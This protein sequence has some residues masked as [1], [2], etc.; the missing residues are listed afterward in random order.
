MN[1]P[2]Q[3]VIFDYSG[4]LSL[5]A[6]QFGRPENL[7]R[8]FSESGLFP[9]GV[10]TPKIFWEEIVVPTWREG[11]TTAR[12]YKRVLAE[13][14]EARGLAAATGAEIAAAA[15]RFVDGYF[16]HSRV[17][18]RWRSILENL[19]IH[20]GIALVIAT[21]HYAEAT[22][23][24]VRHLDSW[25]IRAL[26][27]DQWAES[28]AHSTAGDED[29][30]PIE[31]G[32][33][34]P[35]SSIKN[36]ELS[37]L[38]PGRGS[39]GVAPGIPKRSQEFFSR[40]AVANS[41]DI[42]FWKADRRFWDT[43]CRSPLLEKVRSVLIIDD[44][45]YN[46]ERGDADGE[47]VKVEARKEKTRDALWEAFQT[48]VEVIPFFLEGVEREPDGDGGRRIEETSRRIRSFL[49]R[50]LIPLMNECKPEIGY[51]C[52]WV[53]K[54]IGRDVDF[55]RSAVAEALSGQIYSAVPSRISKGGAYHCL[56]VEMTVESEPDRLGFYE[57]L[58][59]HPAVIMVM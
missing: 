51:P 42:G 57:K 3:L 7:L 47:R 44:F 9:F 15:S 58:R 8:A 38:F 54:V 31:K 21:D 36:R 26:K 50:G 33:T 52:R 43:L 34:A 55:L 35:D 48:P 30:T 39:N 32:G 37:P 22:E 12:G 6:P 24:I 28:Y 46:E 13:R 14:I 18:P 56:N 17:D 45:G 20:P 59:R 41:A 4:T 10:T 40:F 29:G 19:S 23:A 49:K 5:E 1:Q 11:S 16:D 25:N 27:A 53:Y 2:E